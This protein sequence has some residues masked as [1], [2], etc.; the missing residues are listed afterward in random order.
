M[1]MTTDINLATYIKVVKHVP[2]TRYYFNEK[3]LCIEFDVSL[4]DLNKYQEE[5]LNSQF[6]DYDASKRNFMRLLRQK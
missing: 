1:Q 2:L 4:D 6:A 5:Y 3:Q